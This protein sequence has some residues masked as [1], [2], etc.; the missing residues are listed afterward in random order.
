MTHNSSIK[1]RSKFSLF[2]VVVGTLVSSISGVLA[3]SNQS[4]A[5]KYTDT[6]V[7]SGAE[8]AAADGTWT[9]DADRNSYCE[10]NSTPDKDAIAIAYAGWLA[11]CMVKY[12]QNLSPENIQNYKIGSA[13][14]TKIGHIVAK[15]DGKLKCIEANVKPKV[16]AL[17]FVDMLDFLK[18][19]GCK[20]NGGAG[21]Y[22]CGFYTNKIN[23]NVLFKKIISKKYGTAGASLSNAS[24]YWIALNTF[25]VGCK[26]ER[27]AS[28]TAA[29]ENAADNADK[30][31][32]IT[33]VDN[34]TTAKSSE[35]YTAKLGKRSNISTM[36]T[37]IGWDD[38]TFECGTLAD[39]TTKYESAYSSWI[40]DNPD[41]AKTISKAPAAGTTSS[42]G[43]G[44]SS[45]DIKGIG[46]IVCPVV[47]FLAMI[48]DSAYG[49]LEE[50]FL[51]VEYKLFVTGTG[52]PTF[53]A[54]SIMRNFA[55]IA[56]VI[57]FMF[58]IFSQLTSV[59][60]TNYGIKKLLPKIIIAA[61]LVNVS[62][63]LC[64]IAIDLS[65]IAGK[66]FS[67]LFTSITPAPAAGS[68][69]SNSDFWAVLAGTILAAGVA[70]TASLSALIPVIVSA[71]FAI[72]MILFILIARQALIVLLVVISPL[73]F[74]AFLLPNTEGL[75]KKWQKMFLSMLLLYPI[76]GL[77]YGVSKFA[78]GI[79]SGVMTD[80][81]GQ[82]A[83]AA[84]AVLPLFVVPG[85]LKKSLDGV[86]N[87][88]AA[89]NNMGG[90]IG[91]MA[92]NK[93]MNDTVIG[94]AAKY[95]DQERAL[96]RAKVQSGTY[97][98]RG[99]KW[100]PR[101]LHSIASGGFNRLGLSGK[102]GDRR[103]AMG[104]SIESKEF[105]EDVA[106]AALSHPTMLRQDLINSSLGKARADGS[107]PT[108]AQRTAAIREVTKTG[109]F[110]ERSQ[111]YAQSST[112]SDRA[113][114]SMSAGY[115]ASGDSKVYGAALG[116][117]ILG[118]KVTSGSLD[119][120]LRNQMAS[121]KISGE[122]MAKD[123]K[124]MQKILEMANSS[125]IDP[126]APQMDTETKRKLYEQASAALVSEA[127]STM[128]NE[129]IEGLEK[130]QALHKPQ[131]TEPEYHI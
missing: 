40:K 78:S 46:W 105:E 84:V 113:K 89:L 41:A 19:V 11:D 4:S 65:N 115:Y 9:T 47:N 128:S 88:G 62:F 42:T 51:K 34:A 45:C 26:A 102:F 32:R 85:L 13:F 106:A 70:M 94:Q 96:N 93:L 125:T 14:Q 74:V 127:R 121:G 6:T 130:V 59:G 103:A 77:I 64:Q 55:N 100:N 116:D 21:Y 108:E 114:A 17:G 73:A 48:L 92:G 80:T 69:A 39:M 31:Y 58:I 12:D 7:K 50:G 91:G 38:G 90:K 98:G 67:D 86:G 112:A 63:F 87:I 66:S 24:K 101:N 119:G 20:P 36:P 76:I 37:S 25:E 97:Q 35:I 60:I 124:I 33:L 117:S 75:F 2:L 57:A 28:P 16:Q 109:N 1:W 95:K 107:I 104:A 99:G 29:D 54:W 43:S 79:L 83:A 53:A 111:V 30:T 120:S 22:I 61:L 49:F 44:K 82:I 110:D 56:F 18:T 68:R 118:G 123:P 10:V 5:L 15:D 52:D 122:T 131:I 72:V 8:C 71:F 126:S 27:I 23:G 81:M 3:L 129:V